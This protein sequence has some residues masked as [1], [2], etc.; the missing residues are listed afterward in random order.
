MK[1]LN[2]GILF[3]IPKSLEKD[4]YLTQKGQAR[5]QKIY[6]SHCVAKSPNIK[7]EH[8]ARKHF[9]AVCLQKRKMN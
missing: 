6:E 2:K 3:Q 1:I 9:N 4:E 5:Q 7:N 8:G